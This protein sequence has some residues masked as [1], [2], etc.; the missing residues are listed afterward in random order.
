MKARRKKGQE[1]VG[2]GQKAGGSRQTK[3]TGTRLGKNCLARY[4]FD[5]GRPDQPRFSNHYLRST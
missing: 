4:F 3:E 2:R 5:C 1:N